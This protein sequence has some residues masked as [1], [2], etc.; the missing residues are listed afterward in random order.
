MKHNKIIKYFQNFGN[1][2]TEKRYYKIPSTWCADPMMREI[3]IKDESYVGVSYKN[4]HLYLFEFWTIMIVISSPAWLIIVF[5]KEV[6]PHAQHVMRKGIC[7]I[8]N[9]FF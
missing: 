8:L 1:I 9:I 4:K 6:E 5:S 2:Y 3:T 7:F